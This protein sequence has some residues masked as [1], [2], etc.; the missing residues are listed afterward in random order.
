MPR[1]WQKRLRLE[2]ESHPQDSPKDCCIEV[3]REAIIGPTSF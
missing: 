3:L 1:S 2:P